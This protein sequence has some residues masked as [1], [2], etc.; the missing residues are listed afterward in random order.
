ML[1]LSR[2][3]G[4]LGIGLITGAIGAISIIDW[5]LSIHQDDTDDTDKLSKS[6][7]KLNHPALRYGIPSS[8]SLHL[9]SDYVV[10]YDFRCVASA[11]LMNYG[12]YDPLQ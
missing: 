10:S 12:S 4:G 1:L 8:N 5:N 2:F 9:R 3:L 11:S 7:D 6:E